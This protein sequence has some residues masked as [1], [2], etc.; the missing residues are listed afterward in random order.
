MRM[1]IVAAVAVDSTGSRTPALVPDRIFLPAL[2]SAPD[3]LELD[4]GQYMEMMQPQN[5]FADWR[6]EVNTPGYVSLRAINKMLDHYEET[7][8]V[9]WI[10]AKPP[11]VSWK[12]ICEDNGIV[13]AG[14]KRPS[15]GWRPPGTERTAMVKYAEGK[16]PGLG[17]Y[18]IER[19]FSDRAGCNVSLITPA[20]IWE[21]RLEAEIAQAEIIYAQA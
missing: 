4:E 17:Q 16:N 3:W 18:D 14:W 7:G 8:E 6:A 12:S 13:W 2:K 19:M 15:D 21:D 9:S 5:D 10:H 20:Q 11:A 1:A